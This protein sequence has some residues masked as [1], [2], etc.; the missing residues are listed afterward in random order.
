M[1]FSRHWGQCNGMENES[2]FSNISR[3]TLSMYLP[4]RDPLLS[5]F[6]LSSSMLEFCGSTF[7][8]WSQ[9]QWSWGFLWVAEQHLTSYCDASGYQL[10]GLANNCPSKLIC[11]WLCGNL[12][13]STLLHIPVWG[14]RV[15]WKA[16]TVCI[17]EMTGMEWNYLSSYNAVIFF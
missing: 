11:G 6:I 17:A 7:I 4:K 5:G 15:G 1:D 10:W 3:Q 2:V 16:C 14:W 12:F 8:F 9:S 13:S